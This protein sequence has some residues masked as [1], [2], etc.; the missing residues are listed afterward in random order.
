[1]PT[2]HRLRQ[3]R[4]AVGFGLLKLRA[5]SQ[6][7]QMTKPGMLLDL[8]G[9]AK[10]YALDVALQTLCE[11]DVNRALL[12]GGGDVL[13]GQSPP[14]RTG[15]TI[16][17]TDVEGRTDA[18]SLIQLACR[19]V[20]TSGDVFQFVE[21]DGV[22]YSHLVDPR[23]GL[24]LTQRSSVTVVTTDATA[25]DALA[26]AVSVLGPKRGLRLIES[27]PNTEVRM[28]AIQDDQL[29]TWQ[30]S[31]FPALDSESPGDASAGQSDP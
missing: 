9:I 25:A 14:G 5:E 27:L 4:D 26:S 6:T 17:M 22:R 21:I 20:A 11:H 1:M 3:A 10:G 16:G 29:R 2:E 13:A 24:G 23:T 15:W 7:V 8:G 18:S 12:D 19:A 31:G 28:V 30:T